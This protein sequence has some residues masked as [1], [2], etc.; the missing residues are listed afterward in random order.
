MQI[1]SLVPKRG[2]SVAGIAASKDSINFAGAA[3][4]LECGSNAP[5]LAADGF[6]SR[7]RQAGKETACSG[8]ANEARRGVDVHRRGEKMNFSEFRSKPSA[9]KPD[10]ADSRTM[11]RT[12]PGDLRLHLGQR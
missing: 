1:T 11:R 3:S 10:E 4:W 9:Q 5:A 7:N 8:H 2:G 12:R 6:A